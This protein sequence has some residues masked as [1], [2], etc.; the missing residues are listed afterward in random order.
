M[1][2]SSNIVSAANNLGFKLYTPQQLD[3]QDSLDNFIRNFD[4]QPFIV[5]F[6]ARERHTQPQLFTTL[7]HGNETSGIEALRRLISNPPVPL[8]D[9]YILVASVKAAATEPLF[10]HRMLPGAADLNRCFTEKTLQNIHQRVS[11]SKTI[12]KSQP[13]LSLPDDYSEPQ[14]LAYRIWRFINALNPRWLID[15]HNTSGASPAF[16]VIRH[17]SDAHLLLCKQ[18]SPY[19][20]RSNINIG[21]LFELAF[22]FPCVTIECGGTGDELAAQT[23]Y[24]GIH[25]LML[26]TLPELKEDSEP[27]I[28]LN[29][30]IRLEILPNKEVKLGYG[31]RK[32][33]DFDITLLADIDRFNFANWQAGK[34]L[35]WATPRGFSALS[36]KDEQ[37]QERIH[38]LFQLQGEQLQCK[39]NLRLFMITNRVDIA[40]SDCLLY[41]VSLP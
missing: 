13:I 30:P 3:A 33:P 17:V 2:I 41:A 7:L 21:A 26:A 9:T 18:F 16:S 28:I 36:A 25:R 37:G 22:S 24:T 40:L 1:T 35:G 11:Q 34:T 23:A 4:N 15:L 12:G 8:Y 38:D 6:P 32:N 20:V 10:F 5:V 31:P 39:T 14:I 27:S 19:T 29:D